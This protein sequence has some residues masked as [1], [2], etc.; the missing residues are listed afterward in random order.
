MSHFCL[1][2]TEQN[3]KKRRDELKQNVSVIW[4]SWCTIS[5]FQNIPKQQK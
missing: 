2:S 3:P 1:P 4:K 5:V